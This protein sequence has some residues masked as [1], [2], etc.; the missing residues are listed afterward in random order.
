LTVRAANHC[1]RENSVVTPNGWDIY[2]LD[3]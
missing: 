3:A 1:I 2:V